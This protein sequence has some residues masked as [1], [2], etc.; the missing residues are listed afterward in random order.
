MTGTILSFDFFDGNS[1]MMSRISPYYFILS[2]M[3]FNN[4]WFL[5]CCPQ[6]P[7]QKKLNTI[8]ILTIFFPISFFFADVSGITQKWHKLRR[9]CASFK[10]VS[11]P[12]SLDSDASYVLTEPATPYAVVSRDRHQRA[13]SMT[14]STEHTKHQ[15]TWR[16]SHSVEKYD[17]RDV[18][19]NSS[20]PDKIHKRIPLPDDYWK[21][22]EQDVKTW[23]IGCATPNRPLREAHGDLT[24]KTNGGCD[25]EYNVQK[26]ENMGEHRPTRIQYF[27][28]TDDNG[29]RKNSLESDRKESKFPGLKA[30]KSASM[31]LPN[32]KSSI[33]E[34]H[35][36]LRNKF[37]RLNVGLRKKRSLSVQEVFE[38]APSQTDARAPSQF[39]VP[40]P[41]EVARVHKDESNGPSSLPFYI[42]DTPK[43]NAATTTSKLAEQNGTSTRKSVTRSQ[44]VRSKSSKC[45]ESKTDIANP[46]STAGDTKLP[47]KTP[48]FS[49]GG[50]VSLRERSNGKPSTAT[51][52]GNAVRDRMRMRPRS[53]SPVKQLDGRAVNGKEKQKKN[54]DSFGLFDRINRIMST[55]H[56]PQQPHNGGGG[57]GSTVNNNNNC[58]NTSNM[59]Q[60]KCKQNTELSH[61]FDSSLSTAAASEAAAAAT[62]TTVINKGNDYNET[63]KQPHSPETIFVRDRKITKQ[64]GIFLY[65]ISHAMTTIRW[66][67]NFN[68]DAVL[69]NA[70]LMVNLWN[71]NAN[72]CLL[73][74]H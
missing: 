23:K 31:R 26:Y 2:F 20:I 29:N 13:A 57:G 50:R 73:P 61:E 47:A 51:K 39:Y 8:S 18:N 42:N 16:K 46:K 14:P 72:V 60:T 45:D 28:G 68:S 6:R 71:F 69:I 64:V 74:Y 35:Q 34:V 21:I 41:S 53:H 30:F 66:N 56:L 15:Y 27:T 37:N 5:L 3:T 1:M 43:S 7:T 9:R 63:K 58:S 65:S 24:P 17:Y 55:N 59:N 36:L 22:H 52:I 11:G 62:T 38:N 40:S 32:Q 12:T 54:R 25:W 4:F 44:S 10:A 33:Q 67:S 48:S 70:H 49:I 19:L